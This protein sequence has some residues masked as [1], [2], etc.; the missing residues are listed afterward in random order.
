MAKETI[1]YAPWEKLQAIYE[2]QSSLSKVIL[3][4]QMFNMKMKETDPA[5]SHINTFS[6]VLS[7]LSSEGMNFEEEVKAIALLLSLPA[8][9]EVF[10]TT[11]ANSCPKLNLDE[12]IGQVLTKDIRRKSMGITIDDLAKAHNSTESIDQFNR[13][14]K[15]AER[16]GQNT[17]RPRHR[18]DRQ[19]SKSRNSRSSAYCTHCKKT[20]H[21]VFDCWSIKRKEVDDSGGIQDD[22]TRTVLQKATKSMLLTPDPEKSSH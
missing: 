1:A 5:T 15:Q 21:D 3:I 18:E 9:W 6:R 16:T 17:N 2:K 4:R 22:L 19:R 13:S 10:C 7:E 12:T 11:F 14:R 20:G 8:S